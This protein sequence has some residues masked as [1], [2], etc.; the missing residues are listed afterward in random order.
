M[1]AR[2]AFLPSEHGV[3]LVGIWV[4]SRVG[5]GLCAA[6]C[7]LVKFAFVTVKVLQFAT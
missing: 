5:L 4:L 7:S 6:M 1:L 3:F 2:R